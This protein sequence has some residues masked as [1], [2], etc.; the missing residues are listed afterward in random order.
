MDTTQSSPLVINEINFNSS[1]LFDPGDWVELYNNSEMDLDISGWYFRDS[2]DADQFVI[3]AGT[4]IA[5]DGYLV[6][7]RDTTSFMAY[8]PGVTPITGDFLFGLNG[9]SELVRLYNKSGQ[10]VDSLTYTREAPWPDQSDGHTIALKH[11]RFDNSLGKNWK[12]SEQYGTPGEINDAFLGTGEEINHTIVNTFELEQNYPNPFNPVTAI[13]YRLAA[14]SNVDLSI[15]NMLGQKIKTL[16]SKSQPAGE[17]KV[18]WDASDFASGIYY[19][20]LIAGEFQS[21]KKMVLIK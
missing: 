20:H 6:L 9:D 15:Y 11:P 3:P 1:A 17:Y 21:I 19:Y 12:L 10:L 16:V 18:E 14:I 13:G 5:E 7:C 2:Q 8:F 4:V